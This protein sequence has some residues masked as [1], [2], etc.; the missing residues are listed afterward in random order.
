[1]DSFCEEIFTMHSESVHFS[2]YQPPSLQSAG[3]KQ[4]MAMTHH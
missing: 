2:E 4:S 1:M 3:D